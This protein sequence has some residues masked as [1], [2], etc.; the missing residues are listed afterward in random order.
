[1]SEM[2]SSQACCGL[3]C[4][5]ECLPPLYSLRRIPTSATRLNRFAESSIIPMSQSVAGT[6]LA[7]TSHG[8]GEDGLFGDIGK[9]ILKHW[10]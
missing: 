6:P 7:P 1:M 4:F 8:I 5:C 3:H 9:Q 2:S 10:I